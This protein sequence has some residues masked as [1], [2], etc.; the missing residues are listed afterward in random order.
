MGHAPARTGGRKSAPLGAESNP[1]LLAGIT[2]HTK[3]FEIIEALGNIATILYICT[4]VKNYFA[5]FAKKIK[6]SRRLVDLLHLSLSLAPRTPGWI[7]F[8]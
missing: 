5:P 3:K 4:L 8:Q 7:C 1:P 2:S 6:F